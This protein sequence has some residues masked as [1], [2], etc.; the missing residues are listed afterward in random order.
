MSKLKSITKFHNNLGNKRGNLTTA[1]VN[2]YSNDNNNK[3]WQRNAN[4]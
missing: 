1:T 2:Q 4:T 3:Y